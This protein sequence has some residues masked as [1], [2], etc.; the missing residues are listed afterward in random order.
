[1]PIKIVPRS[2][3]HSGGQFA[4]QVNLVHFSDFRD[5]SEVSAGMLNTTDVVTKPRL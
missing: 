2:E 4:R 1:M 5:D 3:L